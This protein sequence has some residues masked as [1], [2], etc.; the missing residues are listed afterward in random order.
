MTVS[1]HTP[2][3]TPLGRARR[4]ASRSALAVVA[5]A[6]T[7][8]GVLSTHSSAEAAIEAEAT[9][10]AG[11][12]LVVDFDAGVGPVYD[13]SSVVTAGR[14]PTTAVLRERGAGMPWTEGR[15]RGAALRLP[16]GQWGAERGALAAVSIKPDG[17]GAASALD[18]GAGP[19]SFGISFQVDA[20]SAARAEGDNLLQRGTW[21]SPAQMKLQVDRRTPSCRVQGDLGAVLVQATTK[22]EP[23]TWYS[24][25][26]RRS[27]S[28]V[29]LTLTRA[30]GQV[31][32]WT[33]YGATGS[34][35]R[36]RAEPFSV[37]GKTTSWGGLVPSSPDQF[38]GVVDDVF[39]DV[40]R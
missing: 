8:A 12:E 6:T 20:V 7:A 1:A 38:D 24:A 5:L 31:R 37:G 13:G 26:C 29:T 17:A 22:V 11:S 28:A 9:T 2:T 16:A 33:S 23:G 34:L 36:L 21:S 18:P 10:P 4:R 40:E 27:G 32:R 25:A 39:V 15:G 14:V 19:F 30:D 35:S 3:P